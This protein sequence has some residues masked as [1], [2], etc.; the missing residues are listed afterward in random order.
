M[1]LSNHIFLKKESLTFLLYLFRFYFHLKFILLTRYN[2]QFWEEG[3]IYCEQRLRWISNLQI[4]NNC[5]W[6]FPSHT[7]FPYK[8]PALNRF[9]VER[10]EMKKNQVLFPHKTMDSI[11]G[12][13][14]GLTDI[15]WGNWINFV[16]LHFIETS[17]KRIIWWK[18]HAKLTGHP[19]MNECTNNWKKKTL[20]INYCIVS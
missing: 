10:K 8:S 4:N 19:G 17:I 13:I 20:S 14:A 18:I 5:K 16:D 1:L 2:F 6:Y 15:N 9:D 12:M 11:K 7:C 3:N